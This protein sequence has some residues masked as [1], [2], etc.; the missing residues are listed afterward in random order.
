MHAASA[1]V[2][3]VHQNRRA[4][5][6]RVHGHG[7]LDSLPVVDEHAYEPIPTR[8]ATY[9]RSN[10]SLRASAMNAAG[11]LGVARGCRGG[12]GIGSD[13]VCNIAC[14]WRRRAAL[15]TPTAEPLI[16][17]PTTGWPNNN[18]NRR[19]FLGRC[20]DARCDRMAMIR[21]CVGYGCMDGCC[22]AV[23]A[24]QL[25]GRSS[26]QLQTM[27]EDAVRGPILTHATYLTPVTVPRLHGRTSLTDDE[28]VSV[29]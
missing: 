16:P 23:H 5:R 6:Q 2:G 18:D 17:T 20:Y 27:K 24:G 13:E 22:N 11:T 15:P 14:S 10:A 3:A 28:I 4:D 8:T 19:F 21:G 25:A 1:S 29:R 9:S 7:C 12:R 26:G